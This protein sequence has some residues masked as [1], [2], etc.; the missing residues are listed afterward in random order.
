MI[1]RPAVL[2]IYITLR[3]LLRLSDFKIK[4]YNRYMKVVV[5][6]LFLLQ[7]A[8]LTAHAQ[9]AWQANLDS[10]IRFYQTTD[11]G[12][13]LAG[14]DRSLYAVDGQTAGTVG[15]LGPTRMDYQQALAAVAAVSQQLGRLL[16]G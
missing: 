15:V 4:G 6:L 12:I 8:I 14:T 1:F 11:F 5:Y 2:S 10:Q 16:L 9:P 13:V 7:L 3:P